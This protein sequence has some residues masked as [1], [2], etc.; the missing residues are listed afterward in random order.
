MHGITFSFRLL[1]LSICCDKSIVPLH[2]AVVKQSI[3]LG[4]RWIKN[5]EKPLKYVEVYDPPYTTKTVRFKIEDFTDL[6]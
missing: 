5:G 4:V 2:P 6:A 1:I 3:A